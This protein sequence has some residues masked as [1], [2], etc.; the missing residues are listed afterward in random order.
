MEASQVA[1]LIRAGLPDARSVEVTGGEGKFEARVISPQFEGMSR[2]KKHQTVYATV[3]EQI[4]SG[5]LHA[6]SIVALTP[7]EAEAEG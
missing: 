6:L 1:E 5:E 2:V 3:R 4:D 7:E